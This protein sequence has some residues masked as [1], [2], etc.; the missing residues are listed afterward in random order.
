MN[1]SN[2]INLFGLSRVLH[3]GCGNGELV[4]QFL[5]AGQEA[6]GIDPDPM[7]VEHAIS[8]C[9]D[10]V[11][12]GS[13]LDADLG[14]YQADLVLVTEPIGSWDDELI[15]AFLS[16]LLAA[17]QGALYFQITL[18]ADSI[19]SP[20]R[21]RAWWEHTIISAGFRKHPRLFKAINYSDI[22]MEQV[23]T[24]IFESVDAKVQQNYPLISLAA[25]RSLHMDMSREGGVR[26]DAHIIRYF[27]A[28]AFIRAGDRVLDAACGLGY[29][30][31]I[32]FE[33]SLA[34]EVVGV[35]NSQYAV[36]Y[37][38][39]S[40]A[41]IR[42][43]LNFVKADLPDYIEELEEGAFDFIASFETLEHLR[44][45]ARFL[46][47]CFRAL[48]PGGRLVVSV[49]NNWTEED[50]KD[51]NPHRFQAY[52]WERLLDELSNRFLVE[53]TFAQSASRHKRN[54]AWVTAG[55]EW[56]E[57]PAANPGVKDCEWCVAVCMRPP[58]AETKAEYREKLFP[59]EASDR[60]PNL[61]NF[62]QE[63][64]NP[65]LM[66]SMVS[67]G[68]RM[69]DPLELSKLAEKVKK[70]STNWNERAAAL[71][72]LSYRELDIF[73]GF[74]RI[75][76]LLVE[77]QDL[78]EAVG[79]MSPAKVR[80]V[81]SL[82]FVSA[83]LHLTLGELVKA[84]KLFG[85]TADMPFDQY[86]SLLATKTVEASFRAGVMAFGRGDR[87]KARYLWRRG[88]DIAR[89]AVGVDWEADFGSLDH[90]P[91]FALREMTAVLDAG[92]R[93]ATALSVLV[94]GEQRP[95]AVARIFYNK[96]SQIN[97]LTSTA[98]DAANN[99][100]RYISDKKNL[101]HAID[102]FQADIAKLDLELE[103]SRLRETQDQ[104]RIQKLLE[105]E[106]DALKML[107]LYKA[108]LSQ[109]RYSHFK[110]KEKNELENKTLKLIIEMENHV[111][112]RNIQ[113]AKNSLSVQDE[114]LMKYQ[115]V[116]EDVLA[117]SAYLAQFINRKALPLSYS[118][119]AERV[120]RKLS[121]ST[122]LVFDATNELQK[123]LSALASIGQTR[124]LSHL[125]P[126][127]DRVLETSPALHAALIHD[128]GLF[129]P[130]WYR[131]ANPDIGDMDP[132]YHFLNHGGFEG[133][134][135]SP[136]FDTRQYVE[137]YPDVRETGL[138]PLVH[139][140]VRGLPEGRLL[141]RDERLLSLAQ[142][143]IRDNSQFEPDLVATVEFSDLKNVPWFRSIRGDKFASVWGAIYSSLKS[144][145]THFI[146]A[147]WLTHGGADLVACNLVKAA[148]TRHGAS[149][150]LF[151]I[152]DYADVS[153][154]SW[155]PAEANI[156]V[157]SEYD[158]DLQHE[159]RIQLL[160]A[161]I[162]ALRPISVINVNS[163]A[164]WDAFER[165]G[166]A[167]SNISRLFATLFCKD[168]T[169]DGQPAGYSSTHF[170][171]CLPYLSKV[172][173]DN[174]RFSEELSSEYGLTES[175]RK[176]LIVLKQPVSDDVHSRSQK[177]WDVSGRPILW[178][179][180][181]SRQKNVELLVSII[182]MAP[183]LQFHV[184]GRGDEEYNDMLV[185]ANDKLTNLTL[186]GPYDSFGAIPLEDYS[187]LLFTSLW[188]GTPTTI[189]NAAMAELPIV[190]SDVGG[191]SE[192]VDGSTGWII[193]NVA[194]ANAYIQA[195]DQVQLNPSEAKARCGTML[196]R[197]K[198]A[199]KWEKFLFDLSSCDGFL[200]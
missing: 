94:D 197:I 132:F 35:D 143:V 49:P 87:A 69:S 91:D 116:V 136:E 148:I 61:L 193:D 105:S 124:D 92:T 83:L 184:Y 27:A 44:E 48:T 155:L 26:S 129:D 98:F 75:R 179:G 191:V 103:E 174:K 70:T 31:Q 175:Y 21:N 80:W 41:S 58:L 17:T 38:T 62:S 147:P 153:A 173:V 15:S 145:Y 142:E 166:K 115:R 164:A 149:N 6:F 79:K 152:S 194:D 4:Q 46:D 32:L 106:R 2:F 84:E 182:E 77:I 187:C 180:R 118:G 95:E 96:T 52:T 162:L 64:S 131:N 57:V 47:A 121:G 150:V 28:A 126:S 99:L 76:K 3:I 189:I 138:N 172:Y 16:R 45:P 20:G 22:E 104:I 19:G 72:V 114:V 133:R 200:E 159:E 190:A 93:C 119:I 108:K 125:D 90:P 154:G 112:Q 51:P 66:R 11:T 167:L 169:K 74:P 183:H 59:K 141:G 23:S 168:Y 199:H 42:T 65:W 24:L 176:R 139:Y 161:L 198:E 37:A 50:G 185:Q 36:D 110:E 157:F 14:I 122:Q 181:F 192:L 170:R 78:L 53:K 171:S 144:S 9:G 156:C 97:S 186:M 135:A 63:Y 128:S 195:L 102:T 10:R 107:S 111:Y 137:Q 178:A 85:Q 140:I 81:T 88:L 55:R 71:C 82:T 56:S 12:V 165:R 123:S 73:S 120:R 60:K 7:I 177:D 100:Q 113:L 34:G 43:G 33:N 30:A 163:R 67:I 130:Q 8:K 86:S 146:I 40:F 5:S 89:I 117:N 101:M 18:G 25:E 158:A 151:I 134:K 1:A 109:E 39:Q 29:G 127:L 54:G 160:E 68:V 13:G 196:E 188:E